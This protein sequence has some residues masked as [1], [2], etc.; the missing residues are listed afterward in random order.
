MFAEAYAV[1]SA[2]THPVI[3]SVRKLNGEVQS[4][5][6]TFIVLNDDGWILTAGHVGMQVQQFSEEQRLVADYKSQ[7]TAIRNDA[8][9]NATQKQRRIGRLTR[10]DQ[11]ATDFSLWWGDD[12]AQ[13]HDYSI[14][15]LRD[16]ALIRLDPFPDTLRSTYPVLLRPDTEPR[17]G[18]SLC[19]LGFPFHGIESRFIEETRSFELAPGSLPVPRF[20]IDGILTR[21]MIQNGLAAGL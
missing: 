15:L 20:P 11:W 3:T 7:A 5:L 21:F 16:L 12:T 9:I 6:A 14:D 19:R 18:T 10:N 17:C 13:A 1:A 4:G 8:Q 2:Y